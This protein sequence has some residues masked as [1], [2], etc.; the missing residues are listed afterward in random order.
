MRSIASNDTLVHRPKK[1]R[2]A[3]GKEN[4]LNACQVGNRRMRWTVA[5]DK[6]NHPRGISDQVYGPSCRRLDCSSNSSFLRYIG[7][8]NV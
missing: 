3:W 5:N 8:A 4:K 7:R 2:I 6:S 1:W